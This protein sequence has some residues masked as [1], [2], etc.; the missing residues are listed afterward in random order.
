MM[1][2]KYI[3]WSGL[4]LKII[5]TAVVIAIA[6]LFV[7]KALPEPYLTYTSIVVAGCLAVVFCVGVPAVIIWIWKQ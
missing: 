1:N 4:I 7:L 2:F 6:G 3:D 5:M